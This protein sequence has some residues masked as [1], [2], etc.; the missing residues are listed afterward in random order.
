[1]TGGVPAEKFDL[2][3]EGTSI[4][5]S[6]VQKGAA[7]EYIAAGGRSYLRTGAAGWEAMGNAPDV[8]SMLAGHW[9]RTGSAPSGE[10]WPAR[11]IFVSELGLR[12]SAQDATVAQAALD[13]RRVVV[14]TYQDGSRLYVAN[15]GPAY[16]VRFDAAGSG[17]GQ[18]NF[19][20]YGT[21][22]HITAPESAR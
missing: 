22:P 17:G 12:E 18:R 3:Y 10:E 16:P 20:E 21:Q 13:G 8:A 6:Y 14:V 4:S 19:S 15:A 11:A 5:G 2:R 1:M 7:Y 9:Q